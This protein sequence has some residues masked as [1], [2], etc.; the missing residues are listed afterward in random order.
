MAQPP[1]V[2][3]KVGGSLLSHKRRP[4]PPA[5]RSSVAL[6]LARELA[7]A[8]PRRSPRLLLV[9]GAGSFGHPLALRHRVGRRRIPA[10]QVPGV[11]RAVQESVDGLRSRFVASTLPAGL[12]LVAL[13]LRWLVRPGGFSLDARPLRMLLDLGL[14]PATGGDVVPDP[15]LGLRVMSGDEILYRLSRALRPVRVLFATDVDGVLDGGRPVASLS[16]AQARALRPKVPPGDDASGAMRGK[17][18]WALRIA[19]AGVPVA[20]VNGLVPRRLGAALAGR[21][22]P[23]TRIEPRALK[24]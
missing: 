12:P 8:T 5:F 23:G 18:E 17:L 4:G 16:I 3:V 22:V 2:L 15:R 20:L 6:R 14:V 7:E 9:H 11:A 24:S 10:A 21:S 19:D 1:L 13:P